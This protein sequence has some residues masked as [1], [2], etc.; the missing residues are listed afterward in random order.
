MGTGQLLFERYVTC[1]IL[2]RFGL[3]PHCCQC[4][5]NIPAFVIFVF[6]KF[7]TFVSRKK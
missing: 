7:L 6:A 1:G 2:S 5:A 4:V 3:S